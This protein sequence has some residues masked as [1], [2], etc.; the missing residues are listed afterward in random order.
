MG[1]VADGGPTATQTFTGWYLKDS[2]SG[3]QWN[4]LTGFTW[5]MGNFQ[6]GPNFLWQ[7]PVVGPIPSDAPAPGRPRNILD[8]PFAVRSNRETTAAELLLTYDPTPG[9]WMYQWDNDAR[10]D[11]GFAASLGFVYRHHP[12]TADAAIGILADGRTTFPFPGATPARDLW[13]V[14]GRF[15]SH[16]QPD[17]RM[18]GR[19]WVGTGEPNG[20]DGR[21]IRR[22]GGDL[23]ATKGQIEVAAAAR[24]NDWGP[25]DYH[26]DFNL[27]FPLQL[28]GNLAYVLGRPK[29]LDVPQTQLGVSAVWRSLDRFSPRYCPAQATTV[30]GTLVCNSTAPAKYGSEWEIRTYL[31]VGL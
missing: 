24:V 28:G 12:T 2:G 11:A 17:L 7:K 5:L 13:E 29:W 14:H 23:R 30:S 25:Y 20:N 26:R 15:V 4:A 31:H 8:D 16:P 19:L 22:Y 1:L 18:V 3:N 6:I 21:L 27:T 9:T 10:E